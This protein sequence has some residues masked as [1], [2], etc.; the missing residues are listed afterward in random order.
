M[1]VL[2]CHDFKHYVVR[3]LNKKTSGLWTIAYIILYRNKIKQSKLVLCIRQLAKK[4]KN[5]TT[6]SKNGWQQRNGAAH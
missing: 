6:E 1:K 5:K 2:E 3:K 4:K